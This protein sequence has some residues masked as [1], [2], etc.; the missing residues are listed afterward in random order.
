MLE[1]Y[2]CGAEAEGERPV[3]RSKR[4]VASASSARETLKTGIKEFRRHGGKRAIAANLRVDISVT[5]TPDFSEAGLD[6]RCTP[7]QAVKRLHALA[8][9]GFDDA[10]LTVFDHDQA[11]LEQLRS[12]LPLA[13]GNQ[14][15][16]FD[17]HHSTTDGLHRPLL[18]FGSG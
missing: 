8:D 3:R 12:L 18:L 5:D 6:L 7:E 17:K 15:S 2:S 13:R 4:A 9:L 10:I 16:R 1:A 11:H 14:L